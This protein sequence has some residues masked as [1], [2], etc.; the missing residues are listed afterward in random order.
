MVLILSALR[1][2]IFTCQFYILL[3][4]YN[5]EITITEG[6]I[7]I[8]LT[9]LSLTAIPAIALGIRE[10]IALQLIGAVTL[11]SIGVISASFSLWLINLA[12]PALIGSF[13]V[14]GLKFF[15][16]KN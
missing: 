15:R 9:F 1:Y 8:S 14:F 5:V 10:L 11:N 3:N 7:F 13:F 6:V 4:I 2:S 16:Q 12:I